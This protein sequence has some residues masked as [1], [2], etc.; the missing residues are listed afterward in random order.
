M[1][2]FQ[3]YERWRYVFVIMTVTSG[4][5]IFFGPQHETLVMTATA[6]FVLFGILLLFYIYLK[7]VEYKKYGK[8]RIRERQMNNNE[9]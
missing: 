7:Y 3:E 2:Y 4:L 6:L 9:D 1:N 5:L 8:G